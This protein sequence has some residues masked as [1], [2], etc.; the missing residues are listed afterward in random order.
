MILF[1]VRYKGHD[2]ANA[3]D[4]AQSPPGSAGVVHWGPVGQPPAIL[5]TDCDLWGS[6]VG[7]RG[8]GGSNNLHQQRHHY[9]TGGD[10]GEN[11]GEII[12]HFIR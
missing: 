12:F 3:S 1:C 9:Q 2:G 4:H 11:A 7:V 5:H 6:Q 10:T 8:R